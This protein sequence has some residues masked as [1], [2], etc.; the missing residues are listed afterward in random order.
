VYLARDT[1]RGQYVAIKIL[2]QELS[3]TTAA[4]HFLREIRST[5]ALQHP[6]IVG[7]I[8]E[9]EYENRFYLVLPYLD[10]G[11]LREKL[12]SEKQLA[13]ADAISIARTIADALD[14][15]HQHGLIHRDVKPEN[16]LFTGGQPC[17][18]DFG[19]ARV[20]ERALGETS[21]TSGIVRGTPAY[22]SP[23]QASGDRDYD[24]RSDV[25]SLGCV[26][27]EML[28]G[29]PAFVGATIGSVIAQRFLHA[30]RD[31]RVYRPTVSPALSAILAKSLALEPADRYRT[32]GEMARALQGTSL[33]LDSSGE[34]PVRQRSFGW[35]GRTKGHRWMAVAAVA[36]VVAIAADVALERRSSVST[37]FRE[38]DWILVADFEGPRDDPQLATAVRELTTA[39]LNQSRF[40]STLPRSQLNTTMRLAGVPD[41][42]TVGPQLARELAYR[43]AIRA[44]LVGSITHL[45]S[46]NYSIVLHVIDADDG[47]D[48]VSVAGAAHDSSLVTT[49]QRLAREVR[50]GLG[51]RRASIEATVPLYQAATPSFAAFRLYVEGLRLQTRGDGRGSNRLLREA[52][53]LDTGFASAWLS[54]GWNYLNDRTLDSARWAFGRAKKLESRLADLQRYR[55]DA[56][57]AYTL[58][59]DLP[60]A[61]NAYD[62][63]LAESPRSWAAYNNRG[64]YL[65]ALGRYED[66]LESFERAVAAHPF[67]PK[68]AQIQVMNKAATQ[69]TLG[70]FAEARQT[71][72]DLS[73]P[74]ATEVR[75]MLDAATDAWGDADSVSVAAASAPSSPGWLRVQATATSASSKAVRGAVSAADS[76]FAKATAG[77][78]PDAKRWY[79]RDRLLLAAASGRS[80][81]PL[82]NELASDT[83]IAGR[84][85]AALGSAIANDTAR[86]RAA[87]SRVNA[88]SAEDLRRLGN[89]PRLIDAWIDTRA[90]RWASATDKIAPVAATGENDSALLDRV[91]S[92]SMRW[93]AAEAYAK[94]GRADSAAAFLE[95]AIRPQRMPA[96]EYA[97]RGLVLPFAHRRL[98]QWYSTL[99]RRDEAVKHWRAFLDAFTQ[100]DRDLVPF[101]AEARQALARLGA[102]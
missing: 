100:P 32:A 15:A 43:S 31:V 2:R 26:L 37:R 102:A 7:V 97:L 38:R 21:T 20:F 67:G 16:I 73:G 80:M 66:A 36:I 96:Q 62:L 98:A 35:L 85:T 89:G 74:F 88:A 84:A 4:R 49:V 81:P 46:S 23:E 95:L 13:I 33:E 45:G 34:I 79:Y 39:E 77:A 61:I 19:I 70:Q 69:I 92:L 58:N 82:P 11:T 72:G 60:A 55:L 64:S 8:D 42:T 28:A 9:G 48:I 29:V 1:E 87:L 25:F 14:H 51:E 17:L 63:F 40:V 22:M 71:M 75:L 27:Y 30:P 57:V 10:G 83:S 68:R 47:A 18:T 78:T 5:A 24:G 53:A 41:T 59:Y 6:H 91:G 65:M 86:A 12:N 44:V 54:M 76:I 56:D 52:I 50:S 93:L 101:V 3:E 99:G 90:G 94:R